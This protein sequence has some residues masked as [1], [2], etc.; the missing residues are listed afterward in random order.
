MVYIRYHIYS[1]YLWYI[2]QYNIALFSDKKSIE[3]MIN[4]HYMHSTQL[5]TEV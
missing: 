4:I 3:Q 1:I 5:V 2:N